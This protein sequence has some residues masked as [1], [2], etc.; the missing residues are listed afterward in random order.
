MKKDFILRS[1]FDGLGLSVMTTV[2]E[3]HERAVLQVVH[4]MKGH[5]ERYLPMME[6]LASNGI[7][8]VAADHRG[9]GGSVVD[10][11]DLGYMY[12]GGAAALV[13]DMK[14]VNAWCHDNYPQLPVFLLGHSMGALVSRAY[15]KRYDSTISGLML[16]GNP[17]LHPALPIL[18]M[19]LRFMYFIGQNRYRPW[20]VPALAEHKFN[21]KFLSEGA[22]SWTC[23]DI[24]ER[25][26]YASDPLSDF[27]FTVDADLSLLAV[28]SEAY[29][30]EGWIVSRPSLPV[31]FI[32]GSDD[33]CMASEAHFHKSAS[34]MV[35][36]GY[37][38]VSS[39]IYEG[40][41]HEV[42]NEI[43]KKVVWDDILNHINNWLSA[44]T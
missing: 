19:M 42:L 1:N 39:A 4:G 41:R 9:H 43:N 44:C 40:M 7:V 13:D 6:Y 38:D 36:V 30:Y 10:R 14:T 16:C 27:A 25:S 11:R 32:S 23:S 35:Q 31:Y 17:S 22:G 28:M 24:V 21:K 5:K 15:V 37:S 26:R 2:P 20:I 33:P 12:G 3:G 34:H 18:R 29:S 8:C